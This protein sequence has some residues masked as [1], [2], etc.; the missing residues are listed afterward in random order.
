[1]MPRTNRNQF[2]F[3]IPIILIGVLMLNATAIGGHGECPDLVIKSPD[4]QYPWHPFEA[5]LVLTDQQ[6]AVIRDVRWTITKHN[7]TSDKRSVESVSNSLSVTTKAWDANEAGYI[8]WLVVGRVGDCISAGTSSSVVAPNHGSPLLIDE[9]GELPVN[10]EKGRLDSAIKD[11][12]ERLNNQEL[13]IFAEFPPKT[14]WKARRLRVKRM[15]DHMVG[16]RGFEASRITFVLSEGPH[17][18]FRLQPVPPQLL[19]VYTPS[20]TMTIPGERFNDFLKFFN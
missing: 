7:T 4:V 2:A 11:M 20:G 19:D 18:T 3:K 12:K 13:V 16:F 6:K 15:L 14:P 5:S 8:Q 10:D 1:M 17:A 9:F